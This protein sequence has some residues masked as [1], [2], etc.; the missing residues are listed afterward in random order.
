MDLR[1]TPL[2]SLNVSNRTLGRDNC[3][4][5]GGGRRVL[6][7]IFLVDV[8]IYAHFANGLFEVGKASGCDASVSS[9]EAIAEV[10]FGVPTRLFAQKHSH[11]VIKH[12]C[13]G[14]AA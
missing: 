2:L 3:H 8:R 1:V 9:V 6:E 4:A 5:V 14:F 11:F 13:C 7:H 12:C 10:L